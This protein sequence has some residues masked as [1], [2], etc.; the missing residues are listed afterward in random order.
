MDN[1]RTTKSLLSDGINMNAIIIA[2]IVVF[3]TIGESQ[4]MLISIVKL[5]ICFNSSCFIFNQTQEGWKKCDSRWIM[6]FRKNVN[7]FTDLA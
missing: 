1:Q 7:I 4:H 5:N 2:L 6:R 3:F